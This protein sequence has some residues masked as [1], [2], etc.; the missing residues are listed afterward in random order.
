[1]IDARR[2]LQQV[3]GGKSSAFDW[4]IIVDHVLAWR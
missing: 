3:D 1:M 2:T 4:Y